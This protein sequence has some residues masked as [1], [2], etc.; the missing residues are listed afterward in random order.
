MINPEQA[1]KE[2]HNQLNESWGNKPK[3]WWN[4]RLNKI[5]AYIIQHKRIH[6][7][8]K[9]L[10]YHSKYDS[11]DHIDQFNQCLRELIKIGDKE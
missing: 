6:K 7:L 2:I 8:I 3:S 10:S 5:H 1:F 4:V 11:G 9:D